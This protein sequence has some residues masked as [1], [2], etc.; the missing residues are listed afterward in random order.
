MSV[1]RFNRNAF[2][3][4]ALVFMGFTLAPVLLVALPPANTT[5]D[6][7]ATLSKSF[8]CPEEYPSDGAKRSALHEFM[9]NYAAQF[10]NN[11]VR[12]MMLLRYRLLVEH[13]C[14]QTL[15]SM[16]ADVS[17][18]SEMLRFQ[19]Q[20]FGPKTEE[21]D[22]ETLVWTAWFRMDGQPPQFSNAD[23]IF[24]FYGWPGPS[25]DSV[26]KAYVRPRQYL[27]LIGQFQAPDEVTR[28]T[29]FFIVSQTLY[30]DETYGYVNISKITSVG[31]GTYT[32]TLAEKITGSS[33]EDIE[34][35]GKAWLLSDEGK[36]ASRSV[37]NVGVDR[38]WQQYFEQKKQ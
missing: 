24:N 11:S 1:D 4:A 13:S 10:P 17:P 15:N 29:A 9:R 27:H 21:Y 12:N 23:L 5:Q 18:V 14:I 28:E 22:S 16:L 34:R 26:A 37:G 7:E 36:M 20:D 19:T 38:S 3:Y 8:R 25:P 31:N 35:K 32:V 2:C 30:P 6:R 33:T